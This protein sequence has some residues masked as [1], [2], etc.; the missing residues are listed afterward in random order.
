[1]E[2]TKNNER[3]KRE[4]KSKFSMEQQIPD[5]P[6]LE[7]F[8]CVLEESPTNYPKGEGVENME[9]EL[10]SAAIDTELYEKQSVQIVSEETEGLQTINDKTK[11]N[12]EIENNLTSAWNNLNR[13]SRRSYNIDFYNRFSRYT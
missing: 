2:S 7:E 11:I 9:S 10:H 5:V 8:E 12:N 1:M 4:E 13:E 3:K 6:T